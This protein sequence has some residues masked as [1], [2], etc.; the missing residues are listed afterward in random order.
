MEAKCS[1]ETWADFRRTTRR[2]I[3]EDRTLHSHRCEN[4]KSYSSVVV[5]VPVHN[6]RT[7]PMETG[8]D[9]YVTSSARSYEDT[10][11]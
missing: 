10:D 8:M 6:I 1:S 2:Y 4:L 11:P 3:P 7:D 5:V 9:P